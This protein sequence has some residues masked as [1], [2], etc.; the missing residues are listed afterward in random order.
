MKG[1]LFRDAAGILLLYALYAAITVLLYGVNSFTSDEPTVWP[2]LMLAG[3]LVGIALWYV[4]GEWVIR[5]NASDTTWYGT[6]VALLALV[7]LWACYV[8][9]RE[10]KDTPANSYYL[11]HF[12]GGIGA[13]YVASV[14]FSPPFAKF[15][16]WPARFVRKGW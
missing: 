15:L 9:Y 2:L 16:I 10:M 12:V 11:L 13:Y 4:L 8:S 6:W 3:S 14:L 5:P 1:F 7:I